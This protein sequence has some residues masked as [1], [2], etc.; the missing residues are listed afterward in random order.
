MRQC[1]LCSRQYQDSVQYCPHDGTALPAPDFLVGK[2]IDGK[3]RVDA[4]HGSGG[5]GSVYRATQVNLDR[6]VALKVVR[7][8]FLKDAVITERFK[9]EALAVARLKH[10]HIVTV[11]DFGI[12]AEG[13]AYLVMEFLEGRTLRAEIQRRQRLAAGPAVDL[14]RQICSAVHAAH[15]E[16]VIHRDLK[17]DNIFLEVR[18]DNSY[19]VKIL[20]FGVAKLR[21]NTAELKIPGGDLTMSGMMLGTPIYMSP[22]Q[23][24]GEPL[25]ARSDIY[26]LGC[27]FYEMIAGR[28]PFLGSTATQ[29]IIKH[30]SETPKVPSTYAPSIP[31]DLESALMR[32]L[33]KGPDERYATAADLGEALSGV[34][35]PLETQAS[36]PT[37]REL[38]DLA[39]RDDLES[40]VDEL[41]PG[42]DEE[43]RHRLA[44]LPFRNMRSDA[45]VDFLSFSL[46]DSLI[47]ELSGEPGLIVRPS[48]SIEPYVG[49]AVDHKVASRDLDVELL[50][51]GNFLMQGSALQLNAQLVDVAGNEI[52]WRQRMAMR[53]DDLL[54]LQDDV[55]AQV[56]AGVRSK[57]CGGPTAPLF[58]TPVTPA[59]VTPVTP[60]E[61]MAPTMFVSGAGVPTPSA[62]RATARAP[63]GDPVAADLLRQANELGHEPAERQRAIEMLER[64]VRL[65]PDVAEAWSALSQRYYAARAELGHGCAFAGKSREAA[66]RALAIDR[67]QLGGSLA[68]GRVLVEAGHAEDVARRAVAVL[69]DDPSS[70]GARFALGYAC[71]FGG[72]LDRALREFR[73]AAA[74]RP[75]AV[76]HEVATIY[77][78]KQLATDTLRVLGEGGGATWR[79]SSLFIAALA[80]T[81]IGDA[82][83]ARD[84]VGD[85]AKAAPNSVYTLMAQVLVGRL[86]GRKV[87]PLLGWLREV[88]TP[89]GEE[90]FWLAQVHAFAGDLPSAITRLRAAVAGG[91]FNYTYLIVD[92]LLTSVRAANEAVPIFEMARV[93]H[94]HFAHEFGAWVPTQP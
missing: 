36:N 38:S 43:V 29:L 68:I 91:Y 55:V 10:P 89:N 54:A 58:A 79:A 85:L 40:L 32:A 75:E 93:R 23:C 50:V 66:E 11:Y 25:D 81:V 73:V 48:T 57:L 80:W 6:T 56:A 78:Q 34:S 16:G 94:E 21:Q 83:G 90:S 60:V 49:V 14:M 12:M 7:G 72:L 8:D 67:T 64:A 76:A 51:V 71:R 69:E 59:P 41:L 88:E 46:A 2:V 22:E 13:G 26:S 53:C 86:E 1:L 92:P 84:I 77:L 28:P 4:L 74:V 18:R 45:S 15:V 5:M 47:T 61:P 65:A 44:V 63:V 31:A 39:P 9:R 19:V 27:V 87:E 20:D 30:A 82:A 37:I 17:P 52:V 3:Y 24:Q 33:A 42:L 62:G 70:F 35:L